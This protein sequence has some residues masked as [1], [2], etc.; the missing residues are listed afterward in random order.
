VSTNHASL[1]A[2]LMQRRN[3]LRQLL[4]DKYE[5]TVSDYRAALRGLTA[6]EKRPI[7]E[8]CL[9]HAKKMERHGHDPSMWFAALVE[10]CERP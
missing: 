10:E 2:D 6:Q 3:D 1:A 7:A 8:V 4:G 9:R 5:A